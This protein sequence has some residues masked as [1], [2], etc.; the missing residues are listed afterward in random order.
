MYMILISNDDQMSNLLIEII[1]VTA[2]GAIKWC[3]GGEY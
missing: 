2:D 3:V 1:T